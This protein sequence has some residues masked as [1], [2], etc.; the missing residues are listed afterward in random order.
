MKLGR[1]EF[2]NH[3]QIL[4][5]TGFLFALRFWRYGIVHPHVRKNYGVGFVMSIVILDRHFCVD[6]KL[7][8]PLKSKEKAV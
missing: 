7:K 4:D 3:K 2:F 8:L 6:V 1:L 5:E